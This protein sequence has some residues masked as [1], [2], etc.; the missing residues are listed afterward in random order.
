MAERRIDPSRI[1]VVDDAVADALRRKTPAERIEM[2]FASSRF[3]RGVIEGRIRALHP[4]WTDK[5][6][7]T[8]IARRVAS[9]RG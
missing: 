5:E 9:G 2:V 6:V 3:I 7:A 4:D 1:E 8:A